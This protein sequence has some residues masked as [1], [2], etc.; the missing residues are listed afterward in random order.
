MRKHI[1]NIKWIN[2]M[3]RKSSK[4]GWGNINMKIGR[5]STKSKEKNRL[6]DKK[7]KIRNGK[8][9]INKCY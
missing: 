4:I 1:Q 9:E 6:K 2:Q 7:R 8:K 3:N 5:K